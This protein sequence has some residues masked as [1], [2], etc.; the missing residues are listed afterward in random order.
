MKSIA[1]TVLL[2]LTTTQ[3]MAAP[4]SGPLNAF[5][6]GKRQFENGNFTRAL[7]LFATA[8]DQAHDSSSRSKAFYYQGMVLFELGYYFSSYVSFRNVLLG[9]DERN[10]DVYEKAI[11]NA[12]T[13]TD[14][15]GMVDRSGKILEKL[16]DG[17]IPTAVADSA[18]YAIGVYLLF[19]GEEDRAAGRLKSVHPHSA[20][21]TKALFHLGVIATKKKDYKE[22]VFYFQ[23]VTDLTRGKSGTE[24]ISELA[25]LN[26]AR[27]VYSSGDMEQAVELYSR[28]TS[29]SP[30]WLTILLEAGWPLMRVADT[31]VS[32]GNLHTVL[33]PFY[34]EDLVGEAYLLRATILFSLCRYEE[35][36]RTLSTFFA[37]YDP[38]VRAMQTE[39]SQL[40]SSEAYYRAF[41]TE[42]GLHRAFLNT[43][44]RDPGVVKLVKTQRLLRDERRQISRFGRNE[45]MR[46]IAAV[47]DEAEK[48][49]SSEIGSTLQ[50]LHKRKLAELLDQREQANYLK[51]E[52]VT[53]EKELIESQ[54]GLPPRRIV[55]VE[56]T[57][58]AGYDFWAYNGEY[59]EDELGAY[60]YTTESACVH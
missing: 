30:Y 20:Y 55:D 23:K 28:F 36:R 12:V 18:H 5:E 11:K 25:R 38:V 15:L 16:P 14:R 53:G 40:G 50:R 17:Y 9:A 46:R 37:L 48:T 29:S 35:M 58:A 41:S 27:S 33:S 4:K 6:L 45:Q 49:I 32:L 26:L 3:L 1:M 42:K 13:I 8:I 57:V 39:S 47:L 2:L 24:S 22:A 7:D 54:K 44:K 52:I 56:T 43:V 19:N 10:R 51:V 34:R 31:T 21:Y 59:W 60:V